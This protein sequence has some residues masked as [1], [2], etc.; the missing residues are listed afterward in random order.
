VI[1]DR[2]GEASGDIEQA[3]ASANSAHV[4]FIELTRE[5][6]FDAD[7]AETAAGDDAVAK[8]LRV[9]ADLRDVARI[10]E[11]RQLRGK[12]GEQEG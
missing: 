12:H 2:L 9:M 6:L 3:L 8:L 4:A 10:I 1:E 5:H 11:L 7:L